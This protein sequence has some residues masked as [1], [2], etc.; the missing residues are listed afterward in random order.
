[1]P[2]VNA[3]PGCC[4]AAILRG[5]L[6]SKDRINNYQGSPRWNS[7]SHKYVYEKAG[8]DTYIKDIKKGIATYNRLTLVI[9]NSK[10]RRANE[11]ILLDLGFTVL[12]D[13]F[14]NPGHRSILRM[15]VYD[16]HSEKSR[17]PKNSKRNNVNI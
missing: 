9:L 14:Y 8:L 5:F 2:V 11:K 15:Y 3:F 10:Q 6:Y 7:R 12:I 16:P 4:G 17:G 1:M 13:R